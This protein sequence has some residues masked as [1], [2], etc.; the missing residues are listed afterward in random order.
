MFSRPSLWD[1]SPYLHPLSWGLHLPL[2]E[3]L[4]RDL[5]DSSVQ[6]NS[7]FYYDLKIPS[8]SLKGEEGRTQKV[9]TKK[10]YILTDERSIPQNELISVLS[11]SSKS[12]NFHS[13]KNKALEQIRVGERE[14]ST[15]KRKQNRLRKRSVSNQ[16][17]GGVTSSEALENKGR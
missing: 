10:I 13:V 17:T 2:I 16:S 9:G 5:P 1:P 7:M 14:E 12:H 6:H 8:S 15:E 11:L 4:S 3:E